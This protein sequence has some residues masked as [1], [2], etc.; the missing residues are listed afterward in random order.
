MKAK[1]LHETRDQLGPGILPPVF[2]HTYGHRPGGQSLPTDTLGGKPGAQGIHHTSPGDD[3]QD[4]LRSRSPEG[5][6]A[7]AISPAAGQAEKG[8]TQRAN[9]WNL[10]GWK[11]CP[12]TLLCLRASEP[13]WPQALFLQ[14]CLIKEPDPA[15]L[16]GCRLCLERH[17]VPK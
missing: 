10:C 14:Q 17:M 5:L 6:R 8:K 13:G 9:H 12:G 15:H 2:W 16:L 3:R 11:T 4:S 1:P 7:Q